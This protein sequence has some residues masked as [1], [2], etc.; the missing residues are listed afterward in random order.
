MRDAQPPS[1][2][3]PIARRGGIAEQTAWEYHHLRIADVILFWFPASR[4]SQPI[5]LYELG[6]H[7]AGEKPIVVGADRE[8]VRRRDLIFQLSHA[9][10]D[11]ELHVTLP[12]AIAE[13]VDICGRLIGQSTI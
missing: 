2:C 5:A 8:Y 6:A 1:T 3:L 12:A 4:S 9:R 7:A 10:P 11:V 13:I